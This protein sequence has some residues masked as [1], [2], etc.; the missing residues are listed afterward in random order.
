MHRA[1]WFS[2]WLVF[3]LWREGQENIMPMYIHTHTCTQCKYN[4]SFFSSSVCWIPFVNRSLRFALFYVEPAWDRLCW[5]MFFKLAVSQ[6]SLLTPTFYLSLRFWTGRGLYPHCCISNHYLRYF[7]AFSDLNQ[8]CVRSQVYW[9]LQRMKFRVRCILSLPLIYYVSK[10]GE[11]N[12][13]DRYDRTFDYPV[14]SHF[15]F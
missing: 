13:W 8:I 5:V 12:K 3:F 9:G 11:E 1:S 10:T 6:S 14:A 2:F 15:F 4:I 7:T